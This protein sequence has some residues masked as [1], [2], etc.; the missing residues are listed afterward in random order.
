VTVD[1]II[2]ALNEEESLPMVIGALPRSVVRQVIVVDNGSQ[3]GTVR[4][5]QEAGAT[6]LHEPRRGYG[7][8]CLR[9]IGELR[10]RSAP[11]DA[12]CFLDGDFADDPTELPLLLEP[13]ELG[14]D[15]VIGSRTLG[16]SESG[17][18]LPQARYGNHVATTLIRM[19]Y[20]HRYTDLG[21]FRVIRWPALLA[22][23][24]SDP[25]YGWTVEMQV[26]A[27]KLG[28]RVTEVP[29]SYRRRA[30]GRSKVSG[31]VRGTV[32][33][34]SKILYTILRHSTAR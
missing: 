23:H 33:A 28:L 34:G 10:R 20:G 25:G 3:D 4:A 15:L 31:T 5:A 12:V 30:A 21:P 27:L 29:V 1:V 24:M 13:L 9:G 7:N 32:G 26:K 8:A 14:Y 19:I 18:L 17:A 16:V 22:L 2:P 11:P 6:V